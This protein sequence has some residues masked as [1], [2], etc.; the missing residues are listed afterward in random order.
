MIFTL[1]PRNA[2]MTIPGSQRHLLR[3]LTRAIGTTRKL[4][5]RGPRFPN[6]GAFQIVGVE[7]SRSDGTKKQNEAKPKMNTLRKS[8]SALLLILLLAGCSTTPLSKTLNDIEEA[9]DVAT[10]AIPALEASGVLQTG[11]GNIVLAYSSAISM[12]ASQASTELLSSNSPAIQAEKIIG[13]FA[14]VATPALGPNVSAEVQAIISAISSAVNIFV[15]QFKEPA[16]QKAIQS[17]A[18]DHQKLSIGDRRAIG[19]IKEKF[20]TTGA[21]AKGLI[22]Q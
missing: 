18:L 16:A 9:T 11:I 7:K 19:S 14:A 4:G 6:S 12:A 22:K 10:I 17:G 5:K 3:V 8:S 21:K 1:A 13:Y 20:V 15:A 2:G